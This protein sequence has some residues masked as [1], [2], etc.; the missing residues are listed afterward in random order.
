MR[1]IG[2]AAMW[3]LV[4][5]AARKAAADV[6]QVQSPE[7]SWS[8]YADLNMGG[9][10]LEHSPFSG[11]P[12]VGA[13]VL[14]GKSF[15]EAGAVLDYGPGWLGPGRTSTGGA[16]G[17]TRRLGL[18]RVDAL[19]EG[20]VRIYHGDVCAASGEVTGLCVFGSSESFSRAVG[21]VGGRIGIAV[22]P[23]L[24]AGPV[25]FLA[26]VWLHASMDTATTSVRYAIGSGA[27]TIDVGGA[28][29]L[30]ATL[31]LGFDLRLSPG[32]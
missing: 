23:R 5:F 4:M 6:P 15:L 2:A 8:L 13:T 31:R 30:G 28:F 20:G 18:L 7:S 14:I 10:A 9:Y 19:A 26:G 32:R 12:N 22:E 27:S 16:L 29:E 1:E 21:Y 25:L 17:V 11:G 24:G 3:G